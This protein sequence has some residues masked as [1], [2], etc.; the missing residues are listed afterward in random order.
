[1]KRK[2]WCGGGI[3]CPS[4]PLES[5]NPQAG[6]LKVGFCAEGLFLWMPV[7]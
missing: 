5:G 7:Q 6:T 1:L 2:L 4:C 3:H